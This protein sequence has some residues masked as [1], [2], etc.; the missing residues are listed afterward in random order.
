MCQLHDASVLLL[1]PDKRTEAVSLQ[2]L[3]LLP[4]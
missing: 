1:L 4:G 2:Q 3:L